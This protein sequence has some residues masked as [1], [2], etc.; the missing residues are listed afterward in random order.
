MREFVAWFGFIITGVLIFF[1]IITLFAGG[2]HAMSNGLVFL[3]GGILASFLTILF[4]K[5]TTVKKRKGK[6]AK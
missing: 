4:L 6:Q 2:T 5:K 3:I 1:G